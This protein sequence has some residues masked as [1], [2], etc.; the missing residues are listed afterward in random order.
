LVHFSSGLKSHPVEGLLDERQGT[1][2]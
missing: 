1:S 2:F